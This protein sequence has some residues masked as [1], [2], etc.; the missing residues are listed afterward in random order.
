MQFMRF[1]V[2][3]L[4]SSLAAAQCEKAAWTVDDDGVAGVV[5][6]EGKPVKQAKVHLQSAQKTPLSRLS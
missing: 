1:V 3:L 5:S 2:L 6:N 4:L